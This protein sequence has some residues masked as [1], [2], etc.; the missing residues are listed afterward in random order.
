M[1]NKYP[2]A[3]SNRLKNIHNMIMSY[4]VGFDFFSKWQVNKG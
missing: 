1:D 2:I 4:R 3:V